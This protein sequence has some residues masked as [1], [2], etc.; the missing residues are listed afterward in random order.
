MG[1]SRKAVQDFHSYYG[2]LDE[3]KNYR[4]FSPYRSFEQ[5]KKAYQNLFE[6]PSI[7]KELTN[8]LENLQSPEARD[9]IYTK[10]RIADGREK[11]WFTSK[12]KPGVLGYLIPV[13][14]KQGHQKYPRLTGIGR[15]TNQL[16][17]LGAHR[18][19]R[20]AVLGDLNNRIKKT[21]GGVNHEGTNKTMWC[22]FE[23]DIISC[24]LKILASL[25]IGTP[26]LAQVFREKKNVWKSIIETFSLET[27]KEFDFSFLK[28]CVKKLAYKC[29][30]GGRID[31]VESI[32]KTLED[33]ERILNKDLKRL[34]I[35]LNQNALLKEFDRLNIE[36]MDRF[37]RTKTAQVYTP[38]SEKPY[39]FK[40]PILEGPDHENFTANSCRVASQVVIGVEVFEL[41]LLLEG[42]AVLKYPWIPISFHHDGFAI[43]APSEDLEKKRQRLEEYVTERLKPVG[44]LDMELEITPYNKSLLSAKEILELEN[45]ERANQIRIE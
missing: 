21:L 35:E 42:M 19:F 22:I 43:L 17:L 18:A 37:K 30:Q 28:A 32:R 27:K 3:L 15:S 33:E 4:P 40:K 8:F 38:L 26:R 13:G 14:Y 5:V 11:S 31:S 7:W 16:G 44:I 41:I 20:N 36:I 24:H 34:C 45:R 6:L 10:L 29:L 2:H 12:R 39:I 23:L 1:L 9:K 25:E